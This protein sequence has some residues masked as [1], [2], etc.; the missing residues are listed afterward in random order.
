MI[1]YSG[2]V[3]PFY[4]ASIFTRFLTSFAPLPTTGICETWGIAA[5][6]ED[7][8]RA[9]HES[10]RD[11]FKAHFAPLFKRHVPDEGELLTKAGIRSVHPRVHVV[12]ITLVILGW[13]DLKGKLIDIFKQQIG[14]TSKPSKL[15]DVIFRWCRVFNI[16]LQVPK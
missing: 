3:G 9:N 1:T 4:I 14:I 15:G 2:K 6:E 5:E 8:I 10:F 7:V 13:S 12:N 11:F 16:L